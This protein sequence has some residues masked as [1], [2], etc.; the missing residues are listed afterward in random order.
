MGAGVGAVD[1]RREFLTGPTEGAE[2]IR[3][4]GIRQVAGRVAPALYHRLV[5]G[6]PG[7]EAIGWRSTDGALRTVAVRLHL[8]DEARVFSISGD[9]VAKSRGDDAKLLDW[10]RSDAER[11]GFAFI[12]ELVEGSDSGISVKKLFE[13]AGLPAP[14]AERLVVVFGERMYRATL[15]EEARR[16]R[17]HPIGSWRPLPETFR[18]LDWTACSESQRSDLRSRLEEME[19]YPDVDPFLRESDCEPRTSMAIVQHDSI[20]GW[21]ISHRHED[22]ILRQTVS[23]ID[24]RLQKLGLI[25]PAYV[26]LIR[27]VT[28]QLGW[29]TRMR[30]TVD[31][32][33]AR[34]LA[35]VVRRRWAMYADSI[36]TAWKSTVAAPSDPGGPVSATIRPADSQACDRG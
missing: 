33:L 25:Y 20:V 3:G 21:L 16:D 22:G 28:E 5:E 8:D 32:K 11:R 4:L 24:P 30:F 6:M 26:E 17:N 23:F 15:S 1:D 12:A 2:P 35:A 18:I 36:E 27:R 19:V 29:E 14:T 9:E 34:G 13:R 10:M 7:L 31:L